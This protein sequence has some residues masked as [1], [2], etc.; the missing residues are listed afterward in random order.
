MKKIICDTN[1]WYN[2]GNG[3]IQKP[4][5]VKLIATWINIV[6]IGFAHPEIKPKLNEDE[7]KRAAEAILKFSD[8]IIEMESFCYAAK[9]LIPQ[10]DVSVKPI[11]GVLHQIVNE[12]LPSLQVYLEDKNYYDLYMSTK[13][14]HSEFINTTKREFRNKK[15][16]NSSDKQRFKNSDQE[17]I[18]EF[19]VEFLRDNR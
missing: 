13:S 1:I 17:Q 8:D 14:N 11:I 15:L 12:G 19:I 10:L 4:D 3:K 7:C 16:Q 18:Q 6:E 9:R 2:L 5:N